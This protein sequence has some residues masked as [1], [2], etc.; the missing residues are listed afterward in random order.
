MSKR[1]EVVYENGVLRPLEPLMLR[2]HQHVSIVVQDDADSPAA[3][4]WLDTECITLSD[5][6][7]DETVNL[8]AV[9]RALSKIQGSMTPDFIAER[10]E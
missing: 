2:D 4:D 1:I 8:V 9:R 10:H 3:E 7:A 6:E 5:A